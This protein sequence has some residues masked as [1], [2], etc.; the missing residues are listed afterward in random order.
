LEILIVVLVGALI[1]ILGHPQYEEK[2][3]INK[4]YQVRVNM[5]TLR[6]AVENYA[7]YNEGKFPNSPQDFKELYTPPLNPYQKKSINQEDIVIFQ[8]SSKEEPKNQSP[9]S[10]NGKIHGPPG[11]LAYGYFI[12][13]EDTLPCAYGILGFDNKGVPLAEKLPSGETKIF[14]LYE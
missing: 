4:R 3:K 13:E 7:A 14:V 12:A 9:D 11:G 2:D 8:Y 1:W 5:Y 6:K 10:Q